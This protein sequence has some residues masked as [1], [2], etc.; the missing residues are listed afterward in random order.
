MEDIPEEC[1]HR[2][3]FKGSTEF[4]HLEKESRGFGNKNG[5]DRTTPGIFDRSPPFSAAGSPSKNFNVGMR[6]RHP[7]WG[8]GIIRR[9]DGPEGDQRV[10]VDFPRVG[11][12]RLAIN[13]AR[14]EKVSG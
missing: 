13:M 10:T 11:V 7:L 8:E 3:E 4:S 6:V 5:F 9:S 14:L 2:T 12:K 1:L